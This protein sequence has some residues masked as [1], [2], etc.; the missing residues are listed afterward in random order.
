MHACGASNDVI[1][2]EMLRE[3]YRIEA[4]IEECSRRYR[5][6]IVDGTAPNPHF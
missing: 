5:H 2:V 1:T 3:I 6:V 4:R